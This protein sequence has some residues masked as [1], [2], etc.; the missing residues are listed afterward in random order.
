M[1]NHHHRSAFYL[2]SCYCITSTWSMIIIIDQYLTS[3]NACTKINFLSFQSSSMYTLCVLYIYNVDMLKWPKHRGDENTIHIVFCFLLCTGWAKEYWDQAF[4]EQHQGSGQ[5]GWRCQQEGQ[6]K[7]TQ[8]RDERQE[9]SRDQSYPDGWGHRNTQKETDRAGCRAQGEGT[10]TE[11]GLEYT[12][13]Y[14]HTVTVPFIDNWKIKFRQSKHC[15]NIIIH[16]N[17]FSSM[18]WRLHV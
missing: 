16:W 17:K 9:E 1:H 12:C 2:P 4:E 14:K 8:P 6:G 18:H 13:M 5:H 3:Y 7:R 11:K 10:I 15:R